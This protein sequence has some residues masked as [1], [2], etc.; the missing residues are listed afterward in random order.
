MFKWNSRYICVHGFMSHQNISSFILNIFNFLGIN[1]S[2]RIASPNYCQLKAHRIASQRAHFRNFMTCEQEGGA[3][4]RVGWRK[5]RATGGR[6]GSL[7]RWAVLSAAGVSNRLRTSERAL[8]CNCFAVGACIERFHGGGWKREN[9]CGDGRVVLRRRGK[10]EE[11]KKREKKRWKGK[12][13][14]K[15][16]N[17][18]QGGRGSL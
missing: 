17:E 5:G 1:N 8:C 11:E 16:G 10:R 18:R 13:N 7:S 9:E 4:E 15:H 12:S 3:G 6:K 2:K 14:S